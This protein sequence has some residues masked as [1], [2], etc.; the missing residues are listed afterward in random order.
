MIAIIAVT[1]LVTGVVL[2]PGWRESRI[3]VAVAQSQP[4]AFWWPP[5]WRA[6]YEA[7]IERRRSRALVEQAEKELSRA[8]EASTEADNTARLRALLEQ[9]REV[10][11]TNAAARPPPHGLSE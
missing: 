8:I 5:A 7:R 9:V 3:T 2:Y 6:E 11:E 10:D 4:P 1:V